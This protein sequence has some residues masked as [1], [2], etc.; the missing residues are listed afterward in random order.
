MLTDKERLADFL[1]LHHSDCNLNCL[2]EKNEGAMAF[3]GRPTQK[4][5]LDEAQHIM[6]L[7]G[8]AELEN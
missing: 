4:D 8:I 1:A 5:Y 3:S 2:P 6:E 7:L